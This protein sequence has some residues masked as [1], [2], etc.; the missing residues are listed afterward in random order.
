MKNLFTD[1]FFRFLLGFVGILFLSFAVTFAA[2]QYTIWES[3]D[4]ISAEASAGK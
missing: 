1:T 4:S 2:D 3:E